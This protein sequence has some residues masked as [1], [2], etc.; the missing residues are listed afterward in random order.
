LK[1]EAACA[2]GPAEQ[3]VS[4]LEDMAAAAT[5]GLSDAT[6]LAGTRGFSQ[7]LWVASVAQLVA[8][9]WCV[10]VWTMEQG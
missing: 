4:E 10:W 6:T 7:A 8:P 2:I 3:H 9:L 1:V 5:V